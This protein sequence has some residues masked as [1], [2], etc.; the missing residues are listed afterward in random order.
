MSVTAQLSIR[1][2][3]PLPCMVLWEGGPAARTGLATTVPLC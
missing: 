2:V 3:T 1:P